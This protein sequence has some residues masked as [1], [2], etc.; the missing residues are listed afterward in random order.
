MAPPRPA[1]CSTDLCKL[2]PGYCPTDDDDESANSFT[3]VVKRGV[4]DLTYSNALDKR[5]NEKSYYPNLLSVIIYS[6]AY[7]LVTE[8]FDL[9]N[10]GQVIRSFFQL[11]QGYCTGTAIRVGNV[12]GGPNPPG[13]PDLQ[14][15]HPMDVSIL[16]QA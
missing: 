9:P 5:G 14:S 8:L 15:E 1:S 6:V 10:A 2:W 4:L 13:L 11:I 16:C 12:P 3:P 7:P